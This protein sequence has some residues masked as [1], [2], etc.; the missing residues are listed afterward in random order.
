MTRM[1]D[2][3]RV[4][5]VFS[6]RTF[7]QALLA[8]TFMVCTVLWISSTKVLV[9]SGWRENGQV[10]VCTYFTGFQVQERQYAKA[11]GDGD[12]ACPMLRLG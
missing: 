5:L 10:L 9:S 4:D 12:P 7:D 2:Q 11:P 3:F 6:A 1:R 8:V